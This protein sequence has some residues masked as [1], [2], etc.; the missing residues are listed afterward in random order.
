MPRSHEV[1]IQ[2]VLSHLRSNLSEPLNLASVAKFVGCSRSWL[3]EIFMQ[4]TG[5]GPISHLIELRM[6]KAKDLLRNTEMSISEIAIACGFGSHAYFSNAFHSAV[7]L[8]PSGF[9]KHAQSALGSGKGARPGEPAPHLWLADTMRNDSL[10]SRWNP[11]A[12]IWTQ[13]SDCVI[14]EGEEDAFLELKRLLPDNFH[15]ALELRLDS[16]RGT[17]A[18]VIELIFCEQ[19]TD[20]PF[21]TLRVHDPY[22]VECTLF[23]RNTLVQESAFS[24]V[25]IGAWHR[26]EITLNDDSFTFLLDG[27]ERILFRDPFPAPY[28]KRCRLMIHGWQSRFGLRNVTIEDLGFLPFGRT[29]RQ[30]DALY[31]LGLMQQARQVYQRMLDTETNPT[32][33]TELHC[34]I[35]LCSLGEN[36]FGEARQRAQKASAFPLSDFWAQQAAL[37]LL[38]ADWRENR[39]QDLLARMGT[40]TPRAAIR[41]RVKGII[42]QASADFDL[43]GY[44]EESLS[45]RSSLRDNEDGKSPQYL[46]CL[47]LICESLVHLNRLESA[48]AHLH[49]IADLGRA[50]KHPNEFWLFTLADTL[51]LLG[52]SSESI[53]IIQSMRNRTQ[54]QPTLARCDVYEALCLRAQGKLSEAISV[55][56]IVPVHHSKAKGMIAYA[57]LC[58]SSILVSLGRPDEAL[59]RI[60]EVAHSG[61]RDWVLGKG[62]KS[63]YEYPA[64]LVEG[65]Y[66]KAAEILLFDS[67]MDDANASLH[68]RQAVSGALV[69]AIADR[70]EDCIRGLEETARRFPEARVRY[71]A[72]LARALAQGIRNSGSS[73][74]S[75]TVVPSFE[76]M[77]YPLPIR[78]EMF[79]LAGSLFLHM[80]EKASGLALLWRSAEEDP[81]NLWPAVLAKSKLEAERRKTEG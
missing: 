24:Q 13:D 28:E 29:V 60:A 18:P 62:Y 38:E 69:L 36:D 33:I 64:F 15:L 55:L 57:K 27:Q 63:R 16:F 43:R 11:R 53:E 12:G 32:D 8:S 81:S 71:F 51:N 21:Y 41:C 78:S 52:R 66:A 25:R 9:R 44:F 7:K 45:L 26:I 75:G 6:Q 30:A 59:A 68:A 67:T 31:N 74:W 2:N 65:D 20:S 48:I 73:D 23:R 22:G 46:A 14:G 50:H 56:D 19:K 80:G 42:Q 34:K 10:A 70:K 61:E 37:V 58:A 40:L 4:S 49:E 5:K 1:I 3:V 72:S 76:K 79:F 47:V 54:D 77:P 35:S 17:L 39:I